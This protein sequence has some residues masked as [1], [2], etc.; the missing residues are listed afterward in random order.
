MN[1]IE[2][3]E[4]LNYCEFGGPFWQSHPCTFND[5]QHE[6]KDV[7]NELGISGKNSLL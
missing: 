1:D 3:Q 4:I 2:I 6:F 5:F 7:V